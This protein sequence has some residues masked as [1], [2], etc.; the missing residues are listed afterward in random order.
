MAHA[1]EHIAVRFF[2]GAPFAG[3]GRVISRRQR[4]FAQFC[5]GRFCRARPDYKSDSGSMDGTV[6]PIALKNV[7]TMRGDAVCD[8][9]VLHAS[10]LV[11]GSYII[12]CSFFQ[13]MLKK[14]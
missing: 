2:R 3:E 8:A 6:F 14:C 11:T 7:G 13:K 10:W 9:S 1:S 4:E 12:R 5:G